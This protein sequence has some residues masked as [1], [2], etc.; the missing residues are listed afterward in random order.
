MIPPAVEIVTVSQLPAA[1]HR[2]LWHGPWGALLLIG[3]AHRLQRALFQGPQPAVAPPATPLPPPWGTQDPL[4]LTLRGTDFQQ[5]V[6]QALAELRPGERVHY[7]ELAA[8]VDRRTA[9]RAVA[10]AVAANPVP[11]LLPCHRVIRRDG[12]A[13]QYIGGRARKHR[14]LAWETPTGVTPNVPDT[15]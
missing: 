5:S 10:S 11:V 13:G 14:L 8:R 7:G 6:W 2:G 15:P 12:T 9:V 1:P 4:R 3:D